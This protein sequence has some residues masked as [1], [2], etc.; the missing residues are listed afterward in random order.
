MDYLSHHVL[1]VDADAGE[2][3]FLETASKQIGEPFGLIFQNG[4]PFLQASIANY[5]ESS[6]LLDTGSF[7]LGSGSLEKQVWAELVDKGRMRASGT[8]DEL[9]AF[10]F[11]KT[12]LAQGGSIVLKDLSVQEPV[13]FRF[14]Q[15]ILGLGFLSRFRFTRLPNKVIYLSKGRSMTYGRDLSGMFL[16]RKNAHFGRL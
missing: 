13:F 8:L 14:D 5:G 11:V 2:C 1:H 9:T 12:D 6:F 15:S 4:L 10:G 7:G 3:L 16:V